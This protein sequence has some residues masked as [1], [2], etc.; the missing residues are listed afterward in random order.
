[1]ELQ[2]NLYE[3]K[4]NENCETFF[5]ATID[6]SKV[7]ENSVQKASDTKKDILLEASSNLENNLYNFEW[8][9]HPIFQMRLINLSFTD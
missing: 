4:V 7:A 1:M 8:I 2:L 9:K 3:A 5:N 6:N